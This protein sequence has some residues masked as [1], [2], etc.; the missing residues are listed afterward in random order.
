MAS[1][2]FPVWVIVASLLGCGRSSVELNLVERSADLELTVANHLPE[3][4]NLLEGGGLGAPKQFGAIR[5]EII[6]GHGALPMCVF[7]DP[8]PSQVRIPPGSS[9]KLKFDIG[10]LERIYCVQRG[11]Y[12][13][14]AIYSLGGREYRSQQLDLGTGH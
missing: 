7:S 2:F 1:R 10:Y 6:Q 12:A 11:A 5:F 8:S 3:P 9:A 4:I 14:T 13:A